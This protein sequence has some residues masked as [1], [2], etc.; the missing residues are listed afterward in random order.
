MTPDFQREEALFNAAS[1]LESAAE[2]AAYLARECAGDDHNVRI[3]NA[4][5]FD[6]VAR[7][8]ANG[9]Q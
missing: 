6:Q 9:P 1:E 7:P 3:W 5:T 8:P 2:R 4:E